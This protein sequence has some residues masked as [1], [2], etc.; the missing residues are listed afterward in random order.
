MD[1]GDYFMSS[2]IDLYLGL[3][4]IP[5]ADL[6]TWVASGYQSVLVFA[7]VC[8][9]FQGQ[10]CRFWKLLD[11]KL[12]WSLFKIYGRP[13][14]ANPCWGINGCQFVDLILYIGCMYIWSKMYWI[15]FCLFCEIMHVF[16]RISIGPVS[17]NCYRSIK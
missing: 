15:F 6:W 3:H 4:P 11:V 9:W 12:F 16:C 13:I 10:I 1:F 14:D 5:S 8:T 7:Q 2:C 17:V